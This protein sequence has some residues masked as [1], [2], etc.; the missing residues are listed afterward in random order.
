M[1]QI[2]ISTNPLSLSADVIYGWSPLD[3]SNFPRHLLITYHEHTWGPLAL[4]HGGEQGFQ[5]RPRLVG[6]R[7]P[8]GTCD[9]AGFP[10][11]NF[12]N[13]FIFSLIKNWQMGLECPFL[14]RVFLL[15]CTDFSFAFSMLWKKFYMMGQICQISHEKNP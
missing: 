13:Q 4:A 8:L 10:D 1:D 9:M 6:G 2:F 7:C 11:K 15:P 3:L 12:C 5:T 14:I